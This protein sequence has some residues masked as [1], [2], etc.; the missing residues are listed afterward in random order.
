MEIVIAKMAIHGSSAQPMENVSAMLPPPSNSVT[1]TVPP[2]TPAPSLLPPLAWSMV[3][4]AVSAK[5]TL[6][7]VQAQIIASAT[8]RLLL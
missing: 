2:A 6:F 3:G 8:R 5:T 7:G 4:A 1:T